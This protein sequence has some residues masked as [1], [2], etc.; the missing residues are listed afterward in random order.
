MASHAEDKHT[1]SPKCDGVVLLDFKAWFL[2]VT[3][4]R[5]SRRGASSSDSWCGVYLHSG[6]LCVCHGG[7]SIRRDKLDFLVDTLTL[8][9]KSNERVYCHSAIRW[10]DLSDKG[11]NHSLLLLR[12]GHVYI[13]P[14]ALVTA[15]SPRFREF[16]IDDHSGN[17]FRATPLLPGAP[18]IHFSCQRRHTCSALVILNSTSHFAFLWLPC[19]FTHASTG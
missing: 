18:T 14:A 13:C 8:S 16:F 12:R 1:P 15:I 10:R 9:S 2:F 4:G 5:H 19:Y 17:V 7:L 6:R 3:G 11:P